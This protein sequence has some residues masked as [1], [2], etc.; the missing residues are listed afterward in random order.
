MTPGIN[1]E[2]LDDLNINYFEK[3][4]K[5]IVS[6]N[7]KPNPIRVKE[8]PK[9]KNKTRLIGISNPRDNIIQA[10]LACI[11]EAVFEPHFLDC[12]HGF[13]PKRSTHSALRSIYLVGSIYSWVIQGD[14]AKCFDSIPHGIII[15]KIKERIGCTNTID[16]L[17]KL[18]RVGKKMPNSTISKNKKGTPQGSVLSPIL[19]NIVL[20]FLDEFIMKELK[21]S[22][23]F[24][25]VRQTNLLYSEIRG[26]R[27]KAKDEGK[28]KEA[29]NF[30]KKLS[31]GSHGRKNPKHNPMDPYF[32]RI[33]YIRYA[34]NFIVLI[35]GKYKDCVKI[36]K[37]IS[38]FLKENCGL[39]L[40]IEKTIISNTKKSFSFLGSEIRKLKRNEN[41]LVKRSDESKAV[42]T[43]RILINA[44]IK[45]IIGKLKEAKILRIKNNKYQPIGLT[46][47]VNLSHY[48]IIKYYNYKIDGILNYYS[49]AANRSSL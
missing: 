21:S 1:K 43:P 18:L 28:Y 31:H 45:K 3:I 49:F 29:K 6:G 19:C 38:E 25:K 23:D 12:S 39:N 37:Q 5:D 46:Y 15:E 22:F 2:T 17:Y 40:N 20:H 16:L 42:G 26:F 41:F 34:D 44:P 14:V 11:L 13:R 47:L 27:R 36:R 4:A 33:N 7:Y 35:V 9:N 24:G 30:L 48:D 10:G 32:K 8:I